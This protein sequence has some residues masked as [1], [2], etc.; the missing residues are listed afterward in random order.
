V[1]VAPPRAVAVAVAEV[2]AAGVEAAAQLQQQQAP[3]VAP[4]R[5]LHL[6]K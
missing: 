3:L 4:S 5:R 2:A 6:P 1:A